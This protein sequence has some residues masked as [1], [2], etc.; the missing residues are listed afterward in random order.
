MIDDATYRKLATELDGLLIGSGVLD[1]GETAAVIGLA[2]HLDA[3]RQAY[4]TV[5]MCHVC[6]PEVALRTM[7]TLE[8]NHRAGSSMQSA[9]EHNIAAG[10]VCARR[11]EVQNVFAPD[12]VFSWVMSLFCGKGLLL[13]RP[14]DVGLP[15]ASV[16]YAQNAWERVR[17]HYGL[18]LINTRVGGLKFHSVCPAPA[19]AA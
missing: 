13:V 8:A 5:R 11:T 17:S 9:V 6:G 15:R 12:E 14:A 4:L 19:V 16:D 7:R 3:L 1:P 10:M 2:P 18:K